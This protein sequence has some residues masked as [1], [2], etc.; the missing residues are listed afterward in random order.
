MNGV[1]LN[2]FIWLL[3]ISVLNIICQTHCC[4]ILICT[5]FLFVFIR[6]YC[7]LICSCTVWF[8]TVDVQTLTTTE[9]IIRTSGLSSLESSLFYS[10]SF[11]SSVF[12]AFT[13]Y[14]ATVA[15]HTHIYLNNEGLCKDKNMGPG[16]R[17][18]HRLSGQNVLFGYKNNTYNSIECVDSNVIVFR[19]ILCVSGLASAG[20]L[21]LNMV[22]KVILDEPFL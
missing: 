12:N 18:T 9:T 3:P 15:T 11:C 19:F 8:E 5:E 21:N 20:L 1:E 7:V 4:F 17:N 22:E 14:P 10:L 13:V 2:L 6:P 16:R